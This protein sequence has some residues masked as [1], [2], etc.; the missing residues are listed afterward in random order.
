MTEPRRPTVKFPPDLKMWPSKDRVNGQRYSAVRTET[1]GFAGPPTNEIT[2]GTASEQLYQ[3]LEGLEQR[4]A[5]LSPASSLAEAKLECTV[6]LKSLEKTKNTLIGWQ[7]K[8]DQTSTF[9]SNVPQGKQTISKSGTQSEDAGSA[10]KLALA[11][12][13]AACN[14][15]QVEQQKSGGLDQLTYLRIHVM[16]VCA[17][18]LQHIV[19]GENPSKFANKYEG[20]SAWTLL[21]WL[22]ALTSNV[23]RV[24]LSHRHL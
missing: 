19:D 23:T 1:Q 4:F 14:W 6:I 7:Y 15:L 20:P 17:I 5:K 11:T 24:R 8:E 9:I 10:K 22:S 3:S 21:A 13:K 12:I 2:S 16:R 18:V